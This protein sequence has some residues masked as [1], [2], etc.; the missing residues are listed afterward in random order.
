MDFS[1][2]PSVG[3]PKVEVGKMKFD[4]IEYVKK[5]KANLFTDTG[6][7][8]AEEMTNSPLFVLLGSVGGA[9]HPGHC[10]HGRDHCSRDYQ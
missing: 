4:I 9:L 8:R 1:T 5:Y 2:L 3:L 7:P 6:I 10:I